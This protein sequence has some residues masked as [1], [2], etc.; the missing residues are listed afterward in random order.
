MNFSIIPHTAQML[1]ADFTIDSSIYP[2]TAS[3]KTFHHICILRKPVQLPEDMAEP[4]LCLFIF[5]DYAEGPSMRKT[6]P[7]PDDFNMLSYVD[8]GVSSLCHI[9]TLLTRS[10]P[11]L[12]PILESQYQLVLTQRFLET[13]QNGYHIR[14]RDLLQA[15][16]SNLEKKVMVIEPTMNP[17]DMMSSSDF[18]DQLPEH[19]QVI[20]HLD[21]SPVYMGKI[22]RKDMGTWPYHTP[23]PVWGDNRIPDCGKLQGTAGPPVLFRA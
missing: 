4:D 1:L 20:G 17:T 10:C 7:V 18:F 23:V 22:L 2:L 12:Y 16:T 11:D 3:E 15:I 13:L 19:S 8:V 9:L 21:Q 6:C 14:M 5:Y